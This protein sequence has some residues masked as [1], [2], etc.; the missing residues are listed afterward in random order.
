MSTPQH[1]DIVDVRSDHRRGFLICFGGFAISGI[2]LALCYPEPGWS[3]L[4]YIALVSA[5]FV[6]VSCLKVRD[7]IWASYLVAVVWWLVMARWLIPVT[8][9]GYV[10]L[11]LYLAAFW[12]ATFFVQRLLYRRLGI[13]VTLAL[14]MAW[15]VFEFIRGV[16]PAGGFGWFGLGHSQAAFMPGRDSVVIIQIADLFGDHGVSFLVAMTN[17][18]LVD[19][20]LFFKAS[21]PQISPTAKPSMRVLLTLFGVWVAVFSGTIGYGWFRICQSIQDQPI[22]CV[23]VVQ[24]GVPQSNKDS[25]SIEQLQ[26]DWNRL[27]ELTRQVA[28]QEPK[29]DLIVWPETVVPAPLNAQAVE[30]LGS[31]TSTHEQW[32]ASLHTQI[33]T[34]GRELGVFILAGA[35]TVLPGRPVRR[36]NSAYLYDPEGR[37]VL[38]RYDKIHRVP[39]GEYI[40]WVDQWP[41]LKHLFI[42]YLT[43]YETDYTLSAGNRLTTFQIMLPIDGNTH[44]VPQVTPLRLATPICFEDAVPRVCRRL[45]YDTLGRKKADILINLA[46]DAWFSGYQR[47][48][49]LQISVFRSIEN[50]VPTARSVNMGISG[51]ITSTGQVDMILPRSCPRWA[52][53]DHHEQHAEI[54]EIC[55]SD[56]FLVH[57]LQIDPR[58]TLFGWIGHIPVASLA[59]L[60]GILT[61]IALFIRKTAHSVGY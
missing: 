50:R 9:G 29:P 36:H 46:N 39:F 10:A 55:P 42:K 28:G 52:S 26:R 25:P 58:Q 17:G 37:Q 24:T 15:T 19:V 8:G 56:G 14:P 11:S 31:S 61:L 2:F 22:L 38:D 53:P 7:L 54:S 3:G 27:I 60:T 49:H 51:F 35:P 34:I 33:S 47:S 6:S 5:A 4:A 45:S 21:N 20:G 48:Q 44:E 41:K 57:N 12:P 13:P 30:I 43:P 1:D 32:S 59:A 18:L 23:G 16:I 40:P